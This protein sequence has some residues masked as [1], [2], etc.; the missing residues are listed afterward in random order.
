MQWITYSPITTKVQEYYGKE[1]DDG[2]ILEFPNSYMYI[3]FALSFLVK[4]YLFISLK[5]F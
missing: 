5:L 2:A 1:D 3:Y 4:K